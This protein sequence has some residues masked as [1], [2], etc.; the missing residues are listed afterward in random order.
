MTARQL[1][2]RAAVLVG[3][4]ARDDLD[5]WPY[6]I[7]RDELPKPFCDLPVAGW[8]APADDLR[9]RD[10]IDELIGWSGRGPVIVTS[11]DDWQTVAAV[12]LHEAAH[13][14]ES[15]WRYPEDESRA[16]APTEVF[17]ARAVDG[18]QMKSDW[19]RQVHGLRFHRCLAHLMGRVPFCRELG[20]L[21][22]VIVAAESYGWPNW[23][24]IRRAFSC[25]VWERRNE[26]IR[27]ILES[28]AP[29]EAAELFA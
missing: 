6:V 11:G 18:V 12:S 17:V 9:F 27:S 7:H 8:T 5:V 26:P 15:N 25:E 2:E 14:I 22:D 24:T 1:C 20:A 3:A 28:P 21:D 19:S 23:F 13:V 10:V 16:L 4:V 29:A